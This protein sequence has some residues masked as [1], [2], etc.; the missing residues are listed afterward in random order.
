MQPAAAGRQQFRKDS[1][2]G[3]SQVLWT[4]VVVF[5]VLWIL[6]LV[7]VFPVGGWVWLFFVIWVVALIASLATRG[8]TR[9]AQ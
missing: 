7:D 2:R 3:G 4:L 6:G 1:L 5:F 9:T 8:G